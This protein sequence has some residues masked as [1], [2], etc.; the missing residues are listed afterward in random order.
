[1]PVIIKAALVA[2]NLLAIKALVAE[3]RRNRRA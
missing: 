3:W 2:A 1:M